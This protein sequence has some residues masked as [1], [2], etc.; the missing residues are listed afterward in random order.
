MALATASEAASFPS[1]F[2]FQT[3]QVSVA[4][5]VMF[6]PTVAEYWTSSGA[7]TCNPELLSSKNSMTDSFGDNQANQGVLL[8]REAVSSLKARLVDSDEELS[9]DEIFEFQRCAALA[10]ELISSVEVSSA[11]IASV[12]EDRGLI[13][14]WGDSRSPAAALIA[15]YPDG[16]VEYFVRAS[17]RKVSRSGALDDLA[18]IIAEDFGRA[19]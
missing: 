11:P 7:R 19:I 16:H 18:A 14:Q 13:L 4:R 15:T 3:H 17:G 6:Y 12:S 10:E 9:G 2:L 5:S 1:E 8:V